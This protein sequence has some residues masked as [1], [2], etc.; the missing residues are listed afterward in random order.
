M[1]TGKEAC[2][3]AHK[4]HAMRFHSRAG[5][6]DPARQAFWLYQFRAC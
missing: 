1:V 2:E 3:P 4:E 5:E 6:V